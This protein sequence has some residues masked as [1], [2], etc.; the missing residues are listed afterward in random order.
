MGPCGL[1]GPRDRG[2]KSRAAK[3]GAGGRPQ[4]AD[5]G[6]G[7]RA[8]GREDRR[9]P[10]QPERGAA[11]GED[12][13]AA[14]TC[15][16]DLIP[17]QQEL[18]GL[19]VPQLD[20]LRPLP[21]QLQQ[22]AK[23]FRLLRGRRGREPH[24]VSVSA[25][26]G[27]PAEPGGPGQG[28]GAVSPRPCPGG[29]SALRPLCSGRGSAE[30]RAPQGKGPPPTWRLRSGLCSSDRHTYG[31]GP[32]SPRFP[33]LPWAYGDRQGGRGHST[34]A[35]SSWGASRLLGRSLTVP[36]AHGRSRPL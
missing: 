25:A 9:L 36:H 13:P 26:Q 32:S 22:G 27:T 8:W 24:V 29:T 4:H 2:L 3:A 11:T 6:L 33:W 31:P 7:T 20:G 10:G 21:G 18:P 30:G 5:T 1:S 16:D 23:A 28:W 19:P 15:D 35:A 17:V 14:L 12:G 34:G